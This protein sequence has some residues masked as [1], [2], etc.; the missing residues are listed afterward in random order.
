MQLD[1]KLFKLQSSCWGKIETTTKFRTHFN[2]T[3]FHGNIFIVGLLAASC[4]KR[5]TWVPPAVFVLHLL[6]KISTTKS[7]N[8]KWK[9]HPEQGNWRY[10]FIA[11]SKLQLFFNREIHASF[12]STI[13]TADGP[14][15]PFLVGQ[16]IPPKQ[17]QIG[18]D[19]EAKS[20][21]WII[22][23]QHSLQIAF[24]SLPLTLKV[25]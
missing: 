23:I 6:F 24:V 20:L 25:N 13:F 1:F 3:F 19:L 16:Q 10:I 18:R 15:F 9:A 21:N 12:P 8:N 7:H 22:N 17:I 2:R 4:I 14:S 5:I 11:S